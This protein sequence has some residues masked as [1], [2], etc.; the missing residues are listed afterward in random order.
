MHALC[1]VALCI[2]LSSITQVRASGSSDLSQQDVNQVTPSPPSSESFFEPEHAGGGSSGG[3][4]SSASTVPP[5]SPEVSLPPHD[6]MG[7]ES[8]SDEDADDDPALLRPC[9]GTVA[10]SGLVPVAAA[11]AATAAAAAAAE[12]DIM[13][14]PVPVTEPA[15]VMART[16]A[17]QVTSW[18][19]QEV[20]AAWEAVEEG[21]A[22]GPPA[23]V[24][25]PHSP[26]QSPAPLDVLVGG[27]G[28]PFVMAGG[29]RLAA[30]DDVPALFT[31]AT[32][33]AALVGDGIE[34]ERL[35]VDV[36]DDD[37]C[38]RSRCEQV[39]LPRLR[40]R[41]CAQLVASLRVLS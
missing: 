20:A 19:S 8:P 33:T 35:E 38:Y 40:Q 24:A 7:I 10:P 30:G 25:Q 16:L 9:S 27:F 26:T 14:V 5:W 12:E 21:A 15:A 17:P 4:S 11:A 1:R 32:A 29:G 31:S 18:G 41:F 37:Q 13:D 34:D 22:G 3:G 36:T 39:E 6:A 2:L 23:A 28:D